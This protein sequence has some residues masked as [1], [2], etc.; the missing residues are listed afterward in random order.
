M[1]SWKFTDL[2]DVLYFRDLFG[3][4]GTNMTSISSNPVMQIYG[5]LCLEVHQKLSSR[6]VQAGQKNWRVSLSPAQSLAIRESWSIG[7]SKICGPY[8]ESM[9]RTLVEEIRK[10]SL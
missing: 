4:W 8:Y 2:R 1:I 10:K 6:S 5:L 9:L 3:T 7:L